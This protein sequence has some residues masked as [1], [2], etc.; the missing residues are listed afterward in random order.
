[1]DKDK[2]IEESRKVVSLKA[3]ESK[4]V[5]LIKKMR[6]ESLEALKWHVGQLDKIRAV[7]DSRSP[8]TIQDI[9]KIL[10]E[11]Q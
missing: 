9:K 8:D 3:Y 11:K 1:M 10:E 2:V 6:S 7:I 4:M 5:G